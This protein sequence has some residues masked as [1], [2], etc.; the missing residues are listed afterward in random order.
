M[1]EF[2]TARAAAILAPDLPP[3]DAAAALEVRLHAA[4]YTAAYET[5]AGDF[6]RHFLLMPPQGAGPVP[7]AF[8]IGVLAEL[9]RLGVPVGWLPARPAPGDDPDAFP[10]TRHLATRLGFRILERSADGGTVT[11]EVRD[12]TPHVGSSRQVVVARRQGSGW[13]VERGPVRLVY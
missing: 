11:A 3:L 8:A 2:M 1:S 10:G 5:N 9:D 4:L 7:R 13:T 12:E 6:T